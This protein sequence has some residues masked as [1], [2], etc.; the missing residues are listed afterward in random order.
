MFCKSYTA[1]VAGINGILVTIE[2]DI[3]NGLPCFQMVGG[4]AGDVKESRERV[5]IAL[6]NSGFILPPKHI[7]VNMSPAEIKKEGT[8]FDLPIAAA[9]L[10]AFGY[11]PENSS[12]KYL[13]VGELSLDGRIKKVKGLLPLVFVAKKNGLGVICP[14]ENLDE[15]GWSDGVPMCGVN[16]VEELADLLTENNASKRFSPVSDIVPK[17]DVSLEK[18]PFNG[19][20]CDESVKRALIISASGGHHLF[21]AGNS[22]NEKRKLAEA[23]V[24]LLPPLTPGEI[25]EILKMNSVLGN[26]F[27]AE[28]KRKCVTVDSCGLPE[29][30]E[31]F[32]AHKGVL[33]IEGVNGIKSQTLSELKDYLVRTGQ[34]DDKKGNYSSDLKLMVSGTLCPCGAFPDR[35]RCICSLKQI[36]KHLSSVNTFFDAETDMFVYVKE[37]EFKRIMQKE[38]DEHVTEKIQRAAE[39]QYARFNGEL[40]LNSRMSDG[41][42]EEIC[43]L[44]E[45]CVSLLN[46]LLP[47]DFSV[48]D[49]FKLLRVARTVADY[50]D[51]E[52][53]LPEHLREAFFFTRKGR[54]SE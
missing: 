26:P 45:E 25:L 4:I 40:K 9:L 17:F 37:P 54:L 34:V 24:K 47:A 42:T 49:Y 50:E 46:K 23:M 31:L 11:I 32:A 51:E 43:V 29:E 52:R 6:E 14:K 3:R 30:K 22:E 16:N 2:A 53:I 21:M 19:V 5:K 13:I 35:G 18:H 10:A 27:S 44:S 12:E 39:R 20:Y 28:V 15:L 1:A 7:T 48:S 36:Q 38:N 33:F 8:S 41:E